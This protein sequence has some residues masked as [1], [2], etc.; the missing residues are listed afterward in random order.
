[1]NALINFI[2]G[3]EKMTI[4]QRINRV[5]FS[6]CVVLLIAF[7]FVTFIG[8]SNSKDYAKDISQSIGN[9]ALETSSDI[10]REQKQKDLLYRIEERTKTILSE[11]SDFYGDIKLLQREV[12]EINQ[13]PEN[14]INQF[15]EDGFLG[16]KFIYN[17]SRSFAKY[18]GT[19]LWNE[20]VVCEERGVFKYPNLKEYVKAVTEQSKELNI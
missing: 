2:I 7:S 19:E 12:N 5:I 10:L 9:E 16:R 6:I 11:M 3:R 13:H 18:V 20:H 8:I 17:R 14:F 4:K 1:M 15:Q